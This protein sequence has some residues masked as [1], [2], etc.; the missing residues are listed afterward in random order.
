M[1]CMCM[2]SDKDACGV[3]MLCESEVQMY[4]I[5]CIHVV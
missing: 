1:R 5:I 4:V 2:Y 3:Y